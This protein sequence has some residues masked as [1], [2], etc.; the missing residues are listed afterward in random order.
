[1]KTK[2]ATNNPQQAPS[3]PVMLDRKY[4]RNS[5]S[6]GASI[7]LTSVSMGLL[8]YDL[9]TVSVSDYCDLLQ[10]VFENAKFRDRFGM[11]LLS[12]WNLPMSEHDEVIDDCR[13]HFLQHRPEYFSS[14]YIYINSSSPGFQSLYKERFNVTLTIDESL[15]TATRLVHLFCLLNDEIYPLRPK[16]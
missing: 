11:V 8:Q 15:D 16:E 4:I 2:R 1:M 6:F 3:S 5:T 14:K 7:G 13:L 10:E 12:L 9:R